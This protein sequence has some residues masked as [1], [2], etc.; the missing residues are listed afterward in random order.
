MKS[1]LCAV[2]FAAGLTFVTSDVS[3]PWAATTGG[4]LG[5]PSFLAFVTGQEPLAIAP[6]LGAGP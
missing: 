5:G 2:K 4:P 1:R 6:R 3:Q